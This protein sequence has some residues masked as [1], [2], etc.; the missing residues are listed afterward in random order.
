MYALQENTPLRSKLWVPVNEQADLW[1]SPAFHKLCTQVPSGPRG[2]ILAEE[3][4]LGAFP[5]PQK[6]IVAP[7]TFEIHLVV[8]T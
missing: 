3:M 7:D 8:S 6:Q 2:G 5:G 4:G 1:Y